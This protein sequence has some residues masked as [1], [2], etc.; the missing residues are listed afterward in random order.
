M[1]QS[2]EEGRSEDGSTSTRFSFSPGPVQ[3]PPAPQA[4]PASLVPSVEAALQ[5]MQQPNPVPLTVGYRPLEEP[6]NFG[7]VLF[8]EPDGYGFGFGVSSDASTTE[9]LLALADG[10]QENFPELPAA[11]GQARPACPGHGHPMQP[12][13]HQ[14]EAWW[15]CP[16]EGRPVAPIGSLGRADG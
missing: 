4:L 5:D 12:R 15:V 16:R 14:G 9:L 1:Q 6:D 2:S 13:E 7:V 3:P 8:T 10:L 11:W